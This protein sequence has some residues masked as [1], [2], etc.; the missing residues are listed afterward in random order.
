MKAT[1]GSDFLNFQQRSHQGVAVRGSTLCRENLHQG[2]LRA[3][4]FVFPKRVWVG[5]PIVL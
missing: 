2:R 4:G 1:M 3:K 5:F